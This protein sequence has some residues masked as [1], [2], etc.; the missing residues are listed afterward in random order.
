MA[1]NSYPFDDG[2]GSTISEDQWSYLMRD[3]VGT[4]VHEGAS[5]PGPQGAELEVFSLAEPG[6]VYVRSGRATISGFHYQQSGTETLAVTAN[7]NP[8]QSRIDAV[9][10]RLDVDTNAIVLEIK[11]GTPSGTPVP[12]SLASN[13]ML[14]ATIRVRPSTNSVLVNEVTDGR[15]FIGRRLQIVDVGGIGREGDIQYS[16]TL[17]TFFGVVDGGDK[18][19]LAYYSDLT[20]HTAAANPHPQYAQTSGFSVTTGS[21]TPSPLVSTFAAYCRSLNFPGGFSLVKVYAYAHFNGTSSDDT[22]LYTIS[23]TAL[24]PSVSLRFAGNQWRVSNSTDDYPFVIRID[25]DGSIRGDQT[26]MVG[27]NNFVFN[28]DFLRGP[29][30]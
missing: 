1:G 18:K 29:G 4:G 25:P 21:L 13:E 30:L 16:P 5:V 2:P 23:S 7:A 15:L 19:Q 20:D 12:P 3:A 27:D 26:W 14:L 11:L 8:S 24:R 9:V 17:D 6:I 10:L 22:L 28:V